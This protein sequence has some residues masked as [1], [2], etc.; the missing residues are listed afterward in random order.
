VGNFPE[1]AVGI[2]EVAG[3][4]APEG[5]AGGFFDLSA[6]GLGL[7]EELIDLGARA[8]IVG[9]GD[10]AE[11]SGRR[12]CEGGGNI[13]G[14]L[15]ARVERQDGAAGL[16]E[17]DALV[18]RPGGGQSQAVAVEAQRSLQVC[19]AEGDEADARFHG[20]I[21]SHSRGRGRPG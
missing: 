14:Q 10:P 6:G 3:V 1:V 9:Q 7:L 12:A 18:G 5:F 21:I 20:R 17:D 2:G 13:L 16:E 19:H 4:A 8:D 15:F 11:A